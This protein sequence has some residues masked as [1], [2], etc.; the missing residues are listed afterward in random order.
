LVV[1]GLSRGQVT[2]ASD[3]GHIEARNRQRELKMMRQFKR[4]N[5]AQ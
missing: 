1:T 5:L 4:L 3:G 2:A